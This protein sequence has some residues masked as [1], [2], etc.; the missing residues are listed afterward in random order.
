MAADR[1]TE[2]RWATSAGKPAANPTA[3]L[4]AVAGAAVM[5]FPIYWM[6]VTAIR[7]RSEVFS[8]NAGVWP[9]NPGLDNFTIAWSMLPFDRWF[10][11]SASIVVISIVLALAV[12][13]PCGYAL[14]KYRFRG[15]TVL[16]LLIVSALAMPIQAIIV[17]QFLIVTKLGWVNTIWGA[18]I[19]RVAEVF[20]VFMVRQFMLSIP[21]ELS[22]AARL[23]GASEFQIFRRIILPLSKPAIGVLVILTALWRWNDFEWPVVVLQDREVYTVQLGLVLLKSFNT[24]DWNAIMAI[25]LLSI[26]PILIVFF[27]FQRYFVQG[28]ASTG[29]K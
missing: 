16:F 14:A 4:V 17:P 10:L 18:I 21:D 28:I 8:P 6:A 22:E 24:I 5:L 1:A 27:A 25:A 12:N 23:D 9:T 2:A 7:P 11:N 26:T 29:F 20:G 15:R 13:L 19:P 3:W